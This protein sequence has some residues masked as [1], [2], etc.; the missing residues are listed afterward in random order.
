MTAGLFVAN[1]ELGGR[2]DSRDRPSSDRYPG[3][4]WR[5][6][7]SLVAAVPDARVPLDDASG[8]LLEREPGQG[9]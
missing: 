7:A 5:S 9:N 6:R 2:R 8:G 1:S 3:A 4:G